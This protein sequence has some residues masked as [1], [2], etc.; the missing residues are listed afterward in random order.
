MVYMRFLLFLLCVTLLKLNTV[1]TGYMW[2]RHKVCNLFWLPA[3]DSK[4]EVVL[5]HL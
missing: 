4:I 3:S 5:S 1:P 2:C